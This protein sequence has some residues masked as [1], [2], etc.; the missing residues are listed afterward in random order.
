[1]SVGVYPPKVSALFGGLS[2]AIS[3]KEQFLQELQ[4][5]VHFWTL[6]CGSNVYVRMCVCGPGHSELSNSPTCD[7]V[8]AHCYVVITSQS[9]LMSIY[10]AESINQTTDCRTFWPRRPLSTAFKTD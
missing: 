10:V 8:E 4:V 1:M 5:C 2:E 6:T 3:F 7:I 9:I